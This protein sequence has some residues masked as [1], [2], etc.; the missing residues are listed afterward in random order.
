MKL[1]YAHA[2]SVRLVTLG[3]GRKH[4][5][6]RNRTKLNVSFAENER[7]FQVLVKEFWRYLPRFLKVDSRT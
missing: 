6:E 7:F 1:G 3:A 4:R 5:V 2:S